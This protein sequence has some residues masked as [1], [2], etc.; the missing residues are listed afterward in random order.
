MFDCGESQA[1]PLIQGCCK[2][3]LP[4]ISLGLTQFFIGCMDLSS[5][6]EEDFF[7]QLQLEQL[8]Y[9]KQTWGYIKKRKKKQLKGGGYWVCMY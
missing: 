9:S 5:I 2:W 8:K 1:Q 3:K 6:P 7:T 4:T